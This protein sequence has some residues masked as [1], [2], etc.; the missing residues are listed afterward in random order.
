MRQFLVIGISDSRSPRFSDDVTRA[1]RAGHVFSGGKRHYDIVKDLLPAGAAWIDITPDL[2]SVFARY[3]EQPEGEV[4]TVFASG[5]PLFFGFANTIMKRMPGARVTVMPTFNSLQALAHK[6]AMPYGAMRVVSLTGRPWAAFDRALIERSPMIGILTDKT[7][8]PAAIAGRMLEYGYDDYVAVIGENIGN[9]QDERVSRLSLPDVTA[10][11]F[12]RPNSM[13][14]T[15]SATVGR[16]ARRF[17]IP[18]SE[19]AL[20]DGRSKM[21]TKMALRLLAIQALDMPRRA[22]FWDIGACTGSVS[23]EAKLLFPHLDIIAFERRQECECIIRA[24]SRRHGAPGIS[25]VIGDFLSVD[26]SAMVAPQAAFIGGHGGKLGEMMTAL[27]GI[28]PVGG[29]IVMNSVTA[30]S[31]DMFI[32]AADDLGMR[33]DMDMRV[34]IDDN[35]PIRIMRAVTGGGSSACGLSAERPSGRTD[36]NK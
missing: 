32:A 26:K 18:D 20:L 4:I 17:G 25:V 36:I 35:N 8:T 24:N 14:L 19:F 34:C 27:R 29:V 10:R 6:V 31:H 21:I 12:D 3:G 33:L 16:R 7:H 22:I 13:I 2:D 23:I 15:S 30:R 28:M 1:V 11:V 9:E 5:D